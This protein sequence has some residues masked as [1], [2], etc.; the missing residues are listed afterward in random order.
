MGMI[1]TGSDHTF[2]AIFHQARLV[3]RV[4]EWARRHDPR[5]RVDS[6]GGEGGAVRDRVS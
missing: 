6:R 2:T 4:E 1:F 5:A 3:E